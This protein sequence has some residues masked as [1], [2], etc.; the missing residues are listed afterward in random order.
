[1]GDIAYWGTLVSRLGREIQKRRLNSE[2]GSSEKFRCLR[3][4]KSEKKTVARDVSC[5]GEA[6]ALGVL[7][8][9]ADD[10]ASGGAE[11]SVHMEPAVPESL[12]R[13]GPSKE[14]TTNPLF[15]ILNFGHLLSQVT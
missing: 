7:R 11:A 3:F 14:S 2:T 15:D 1:M 4:A 8:R 6:D 12:Y 9:G 13:P 10:D 5:V